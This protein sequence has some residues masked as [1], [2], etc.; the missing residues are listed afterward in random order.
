M[1]AAGLGPRRPATALVTVVII[2]LAW[3]SCSCHC[4]AKVV[5]ELQAIREAS[6][7]KLPPDRLP[8]GRAGRLLRAQQGFVSQRPLGGVQGKPDLRVPRAPPPTCLPECP[9]PG[10]RSPPALSCHLPRAQALG[11][12]LWKP[13]ATMLWDST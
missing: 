8:P 2:R 4:E 5:S 6:I 3:C 7:G 12:G 1:D 11:Q 9:A 10:D 13:S